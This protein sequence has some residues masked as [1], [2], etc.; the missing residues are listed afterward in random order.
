VS[1]P[2]ISAAGAGAEEPLLAA[3]LPL[4]PVALTVLPDDDGTE[5]LSGEPDL[6]PPQ[7]VSISVPAKAP[8]TIRRFRIVGGEFSMMIRTRKIE[9]TNHD[10]GGPER[11]VSAVLPKLLSLGALNRFSY[12]QHS[13]ADCALRRSDYD[14]ARFSLQRCPAL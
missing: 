5:L 12:R 4:S 1:V 3:L 10:S 13:F 9:F 8:E 11:A 7:A 14:P 6:P 2:G